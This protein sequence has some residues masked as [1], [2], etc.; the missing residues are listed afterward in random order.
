MGEPS[1]NA[2][3]LDSPPDPK[4]DI[5]ELASHPMA[6]RKGTAL[7]TD[8]DETDDQDTIVPTS[9]FASSNHTPE[10]SSE[11]I[12]TSTVASASTSD[13]ITCTPDDSD[14]QTNDEKIIVPTPITII[15]SDKESRTIVNPIKE[16]KSWINPENL[17]CDISKDV[18]QVTD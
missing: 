10:Q 16:S 11:F 5:E 12:L 6:R 14:K 17:G 3:F 13:N 7:V 2:P 15:T 4:F 8:E 9:A 1:I 18:L